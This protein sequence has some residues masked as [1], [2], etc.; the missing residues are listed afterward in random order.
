M[1]S[2]QVKGVKDA[3][4][5]LPDIRKV[6]K[7]ASMALNRTIKGALT[8]TD[9]GIRD[10]YT[11]KRA[12]VR[13]EIK[14]TQAS[15]NNLSAAL[16]ASIRKLSLTKYQ[17]RI[18]RAKPRIGVAGVRVRVKKGGSLKP[19]SHAFHATMGSGHVGIYQ[20]VGARRLPIRELT[21]PSVHGMATSSKVLTRVQ[22]RAETQFNSEFTRNLDRLA[23]R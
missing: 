7:A 23:K 19:I 22:R 17:H 8:E 4:L 20:R 18:S 5:S 14:V 9:R 13:K 12:D 21:G 3:M 10:E 2:L 11:V 1:I 16:S 15:E 6:R